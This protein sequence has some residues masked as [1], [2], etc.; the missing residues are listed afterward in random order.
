MDGEHK[1]HVQEYFFPRNFSQSGFSKSVQKICKGFPKC[2]H[3]PKRF[4]GFPKI[5]KAF[6]KGFK[7]VSEHFQRVSKG[8]Q[9][10][11]QTVSKAFPKG[12]K[13]S[14]TG[15]PKGFRV[16]SNPLK[17]AFVDKMCFH[18]DG[19]KCYSNWTRLYYR[20]ST[21]SKMLPRQDECRPRFYLS[22]DQVGCGNTASMMCGGPAVRT[23]QMGQYFQA[24]LYVS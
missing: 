3:V 17:N 15:F 10:C 2:F 4:K 20:G 8:F 13:P 7:R 16:T 22:K 21:L 24:V 5:F 14:E 23:Q 9:K 6:R 11:F 1:L 19:H 12:F 18:M